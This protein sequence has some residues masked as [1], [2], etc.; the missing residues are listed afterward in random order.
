[1]IMLFGLTF[2][3]TFTLVFVLQEH[4]RK[5]CSLRK[6]VDELE[7]CSPVWQVRHQ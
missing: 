2:T 5:I 1:M 7:E 3:I 6:R 4:E